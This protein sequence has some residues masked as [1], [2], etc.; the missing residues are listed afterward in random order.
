MSMV[1]SRFIIPMAVVGIQM[2]QM[3]LRRNGNKSR[4]KDQ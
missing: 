3:S 4:E 1:N 2:P